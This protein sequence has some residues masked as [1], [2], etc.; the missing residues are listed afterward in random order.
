MVSVFDA[1]VD[2]APLSPIM[3]NGQKLSMLMKSPLTR[4][5]ISDFMRLHVP[6]ILI[7]G[8]YGPIS[9]SKGSD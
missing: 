3:T 5:R 8:L 2:E 7:L 4:E 6:I 1:G 9:D